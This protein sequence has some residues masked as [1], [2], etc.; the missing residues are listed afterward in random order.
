MENYFC[1]IFGICSKTFQ[2]FNL[3]PELEPEANVE[4][5]VPCIYCQ[6]FRD[7]VK[8]KKSEACSVHSIELNS[9]IFS[10]CFTVGPATLHLAHHIKC[11]KKSIALWCITHW[12]DDRYDISKQLRRHL[13]ELRHTLCFLLFS[14]YTVVTNLLLRL[15]I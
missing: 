1:D 6:Y 11:K 4:N 8:H 15:D 12:H 13:P 7:S 9:Y 10:L 5:V 14:L 3:K 2:I